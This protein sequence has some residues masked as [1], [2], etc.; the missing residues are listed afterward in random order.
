MAAKK[1]AGK[2]KAGKK[3]AGKK[4]AG[5]K[6]RVSPIPEGYGVVTP[7]MNQVDA[8]ATIDFCKKA[9]GAKLRGQM[10]LPNGKLMHAE[11]EIGGSAIMLSDAMR[12]PARVSSLMIYVTNIDKTIAK[13][14]AAGAKVSMPPEDMFWGD[15]FGQVIDPQ[16][17]LWSLG[18]HIEDVS[19][20]DT[21]K[22]FKQFAKQFG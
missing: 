1:K 15:R 10:V 12:D 14:T 8:K 22:R 18:T 20:A 21:K 16:G 17:N 6:K 4:K 5:K 2:K 11:I 3:K 13:A 7:M 19:T 9:F